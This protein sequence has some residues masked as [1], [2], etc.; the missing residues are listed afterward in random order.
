MNAYSFLIDQMVWSFSRLQTFQKCPYGFYVHYILEED[1]DNTFLASFGSFVHR[2]HE[3]V[4]TGQLGRSH[5]QE[6]FLTHFRQ[7]VPEPPPSRE[8][9][10]S[11][12]RSTFDYLAAIPAFDGEIVGVEQEFFFDVGGH[13]FHGF[14][15][16]VTKT[17]NGLVIYDHKARN[18]KPFSNRRKPT[19]TDIELKE[20]FRQLYLYALAIRQAYG[21]YPAE[22]VF[23]CYRERLMIR[24]KFDEGALGEAVA[25]ATD[26]I[27]QI[28]SCES[29]KPDIDFFKCRNL[30][31]LNDRC[32]YKDL[33]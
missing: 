22:L 17:P 13:P 26:L 10:S 19:K 18:L 30:C 33:M 14:A 5:A 20:Y 16:L 32:D 2:I 23:N 28:R 9:F 11:Y 25:W 12:Y 21:E 1:E 7:E 3:L 8:V 31:G 27:G 29:W 4:L 15:D 24:Q 6:Y